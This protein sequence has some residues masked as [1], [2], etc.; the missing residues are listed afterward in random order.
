M[1]VEFLTRISKRLFPEGEIILERVPQ[2]LRSR[3]WH[4]KPDEIGSVILETNLN[5]VKVGL[6]PLS[7]NEIEDALD[8]Y[9]VMNSKRD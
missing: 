2:E 9:H 6:E 7:E 4:A 8:G 3:I 5:L 1:T